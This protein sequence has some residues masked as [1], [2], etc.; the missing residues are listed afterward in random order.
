MQVDSL[1]TELS[2]KPVKEGKVG[3][4]EVSAFS[5]DKVVW[6]ESSLSSWLKRETPLQMGISLVNVSYKKVT[7]R[8]SELL[9]KN[10]Q[11]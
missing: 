6:R 2:G 8:F 4:I 10:S 7:S 9:L 3:Q 1:P 11:F 5:I